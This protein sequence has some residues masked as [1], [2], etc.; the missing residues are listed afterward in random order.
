[1]NVHDSISE[2]RRPGISAICAEIQAAHPYWPNDR[3]ARRAKELWTIRN[4]AGKAK[5]KAPRK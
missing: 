3:I 1:M 2:E 4:H 5:K